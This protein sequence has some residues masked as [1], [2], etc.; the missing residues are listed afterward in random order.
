MKRSE[1]DIHR[2]IVAHLRFRLPKPWLFWHTPNGGARSKAEGGIL[3]ALGT[4]AGTPDLFVAGEGRIIAIEVKAPKG[5]LSP[6]QL[7]TIGALAHA[8]IPTIIARSWDDVESALR[9]LGV[10][11]TGRTL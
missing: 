6:A 10:P 9:G 1:E 7:S 5:A 4:L 2:A 11:L 3:K 8:G